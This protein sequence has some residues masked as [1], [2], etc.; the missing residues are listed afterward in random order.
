MKT[1]RIMPVGGQRIG[2][3]CL[4]LQFDANLDRFD[5]TYIV[6]PLAGSRLD[7]VFQKYNIDTTGFVYILDQDLVDAY[8][9]INNW[10]LTGDYRGSWLFQ[11]AL[12]LACIDQ[13]DADL[14][15]LQD[16]D[17]F[18]NVPYQT[19]SGG[20]L[21]LFYVPNTNHAPGYYQAAQNITGHARAT[22][23]S[24]VC[25]MMPV[26]KENWVSLRNTISSRFNSHWLDAV[27]D[28]TPWDYVAGVKWF[29]EYEL[30]ANWTLTQRPETNLTI[31]HRFEVKNLEALTHRDFPK[32][33]NCVIDKNPQGPTLPFDY[34]SDTVLH[35]DAVLGRLGGLIL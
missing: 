11:Q 22:P 6:S 19:L 12:K 24:F 31:Q 9:Q 5:Q 8:P 1:A 32:Q 34:A 15:F 10:N 7:Q 2:A 35:L 4:S 16:A 20:Q 33:F 23:H 29:S 13:V 18:C 28:Q 21:N 3:A 27:I 25:D 26:Y 14:V 30:L 17:A